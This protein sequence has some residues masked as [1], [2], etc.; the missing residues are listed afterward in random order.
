[1]TDVAMFRPTGPNRY[2]PAEAATGSWDPELVH[3][4]ALSA[5]LA[6]RLQPDTGTVARYSTTEADLACSGGA[7]RSQPVDGWWPWPAL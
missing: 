3:G 5:L 7:W 2:V 4:A 1:M 6:G